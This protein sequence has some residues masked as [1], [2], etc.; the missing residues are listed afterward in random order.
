MSWIDK[1]TK[2]QLNA[3]WHWF[4]WEMTGAEARDALNWLEKNATR[5]QVSEELG[6]LKELS[7][8]HKLNREE[9]FRGEVWQDYFNARKETPIE[10]K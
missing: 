3:I 5:K 4:N 9:C 2:A 7:L 10:D 6:R 1:P 8:E